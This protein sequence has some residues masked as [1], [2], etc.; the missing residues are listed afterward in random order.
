MEEKRHVHY[1]TSITSYTRDRA[2]GGRWAV[3]EVLRDS[4]LKNLCFFRSN[5]GEGWKGKGREGK[6]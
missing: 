4:R 1:V 6:G 3:D 2:G 5:E